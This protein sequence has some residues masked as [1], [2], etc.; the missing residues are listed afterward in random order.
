MDDLSGTIATICIVAPAVMFAIIAHEVMH[1][2]VALR[3][4]DDTALRAG[5]LT[6]NPI[7]HIDLF[8]TIILP[9]GL[10]LFGLPVLGYAKPVPVDFRVLRGGRSGML[11]VAAAGPLTNFVLAILSGL[12]LRVL[13]AFLHGSLG[14]TVVVPLARMLQASM[15]VNVELG[16]FNLIS[17]AAARRWARAV[18]SPADRCRARLRT[19]RALRLPHT[20]GAAVYALAGYRDLPGDEPGVQCNYVDGATVSNENEAG[21]PPNLGA[22]GGVRFRL[23]IYEGP[24]DLLLHLLKRAELDPHEVTASVIT[25][26]YLAWLELLDQLNL[27]VAGEYLVM[28][29]TLLLIKSFAMLPHPELADTEEAEELKRDLVERLLEY[30]RYRE[31]A[32]K[33]SERALL[34]RD[35][36]TTPGESAPEDANAKQY[37]VSIFDLVEAI[38][39]VL[40]RVADKTPRKIELRDIPVA[41][42]IPRILRALEGAGRIPFTALF[43]DANDRS[44][45]IATFMALLEL[46]RRREVRAFQEVRFGPIFLERGAAA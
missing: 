17:G 24:L 42:C 14:T 26:Q 16:V 7:S 2:V 35:V 23:P 38:G 31:A 28:A 19:D 39:A 21:T 32:E 8:G 5:R 22:D 44:L 10:Y 18:Q 9:L 40:K 13:P 30:Q 33:L 43:E 3:L 4:G 20:D 11:K 25:E 37:T 36:F 29:A 45:V 15:I 27:D 46:I 1:G 6:L 12:A 41:E 34:G